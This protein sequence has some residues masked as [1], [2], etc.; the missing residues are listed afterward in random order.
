MAVKKTVDK[1]AIA[2]GWRGGGNEIGSRYRRGELTWIGREANNLGA[3]KAVMIVALR[4]NKKGGS[5]G[6]S[7]PPALKAG[8]VYV[9]IAKNAGQ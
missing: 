9:L 8:E 2:T 5:I 4:T 6:R 3:S 7:V 1:V